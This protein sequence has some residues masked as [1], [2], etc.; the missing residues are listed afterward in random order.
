MPFNTQVYVHLIE[1]TNLIQILSDIELLTFFFKMRYLYLPFLSISFIMSKISFAVGFR[2]SIRN[3]VPSSWALISPLL[4]LSNS[5]KTLFAS[6]IKAAPQKKIITVN[7][8]KIQVTMLIYKEHVN[9]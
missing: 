4:S 7:I 8:C 9:T 2:P 1:T 6:A 3:A 5:S